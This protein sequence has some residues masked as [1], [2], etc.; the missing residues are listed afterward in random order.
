MEQLGPR[1]RSLKT[2]Y[3][4]SEVVLTALMT[5]YD[6]AADLSASDIITSVT[7]KTG[8]ETEYVEN[9]VAK[10]YD[11]EISGESGEPEYAYLLNDSADISTPTRLGTNGIRLIETAFLHDGAT[12]DPIWLA[13][14]HLVKN[15]FVSQS[16]QERFASGMGPYPNYLVPLSSL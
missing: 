2:A 8:Y 9:V 15:Q 10:L 6:S 13:E 5:V 16:A 3:Q 12:F 14:R 1:E 7:N 4:V 11:M